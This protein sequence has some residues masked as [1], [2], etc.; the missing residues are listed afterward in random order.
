MRRRLAIGMWVAALAGALGTLA[1]A[2][3]S[4]DSHD[5]TTT[6]TPT[7]TTA[8]ATTTT[9]AAP[10]ATTTTTPASTTTVVASTTTTTVPSTSTS[11]TAPAGAVVTPTTTGTGSATTTTTTARTSTTTTRPDADPARRTVRARV[12]GDLGSLPPDPES[13]ISPPD[14]GQ[15]FTDEAPDDDGSAPEKE[16]STRGLLTGGLGASVAA[17][18]LLGL[19]DRST[20][21]SN[22]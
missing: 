10:A 3:A 14:L 19:R 7:T 16:G 5:T 1:V 21:G 2:P 20:A 9:T 18:L 22:G 6:S 13:G 11:T 8:P 15:L 4:A 12:S 17:G